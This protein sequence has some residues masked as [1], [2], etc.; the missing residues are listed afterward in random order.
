MILAY[1]TTSLQPMLLL[2]FLEKLNGHFD[3]VCPK[4]TI[5][6]RTAYHPH[7]AMAECRP[8]GIRSVTKIVSIAWEMVGDRNWPKT[9]VWPASLGSNH[10][11]GAFTCKLY[12]G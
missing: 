7:I 9:C 5:F 10:R 1:A 4:S 6:R 12:I 11:S 3:L 8:T 2:V